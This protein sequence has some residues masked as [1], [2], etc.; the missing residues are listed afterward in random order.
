MPVVQQGSQVWA[1]PTA[2]SAG[3][4]QR[5]RHLSHKSA[6]WLCP[7]LNAGVTCRCSLLP[8]FVFLT[9]FRLSLPITGGHEGDPNIQ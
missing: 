4:G 7:G 9:L 8:L 3:Q 6:H 1:P 5:H 2:P